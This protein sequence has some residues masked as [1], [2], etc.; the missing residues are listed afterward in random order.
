MILSRKETPKKAIFI[1]TTIVAAISHENYNSIYN[2]GEFVIKDL[3]ESDYLITFLFSSSHW[4][5]LVLD[6][7]KKE[8]VHYNSL[9]SRHPPNPDGSEV[10]NSHDAIA[11]TMTQLIRDFIK[12]QHCHVKDVDSWDLRHVRDCSQ[13]LPGSND[14]GVFVMHWAEKLVNGFEI[15]NEDPNEVHNLRAIY[16]VQFL[17]DSNA[18]KEDF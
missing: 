17:K 9:Q 6:V 4:H 3:F 11:R 2:L 14:C 13:Q 15:G 7:A 1:P 8:F 16:A 18:H 5:L 12:I 10:F